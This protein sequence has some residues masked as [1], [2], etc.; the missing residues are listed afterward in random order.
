MNNIVRISVRNLIE[1]IL[2]SGDIDSSKKTV[3]KEAMLLGG[4]IHRKIQKSMGSNYQAEVALKQS[5]ERGVYE[6]IV[7]GRADGIIQEEDMVVVDEIK[8]VYWNLYKVEEPKELHL[9]QAKCYAYMYGSEHGMD[10]MGVQITYCNMETEEVKRFRDV[11]TLKEL[12]MWFVEL[13][14]RYDKWAEFQITWKEK[15][16]DSI[17]NIEFPFVY[18]EGQ[19]E[20]VTSVYKTVLRKKKLFIQAPTGIGKTLATIFPSVKAVGEGLGDKIFYLTAKTITRT[21]AEQ[22]FLELKKQQLQY[23]VLTLTAKD[24]ICFLEECECNPRTC[25]YAKGH[26]DR[27]NEAVYDLLINNDDVSRELLEKHAQQYKVCPFEM[28]LDLSLWVDGIICDYNYLFD[29]NAYL[30]RFFS[31]GVREDYIFLIDEAHNLVERGREMYSADLYKE[32]FLELKKSVKYHDLKLA[33]KLESCNKFLLALKRECETYE[34]IQNIGGFPL[35]LMNLMTEMERV[36]EEIEDGD[37]REKVLELYFRVRM[38]LNIYDRI[39]E[40]YVI[41]TELDGMNQF[42]VRLYCVNPSV[43]LQSCLDRGISTV[44]FSATLLP[45]QYYKNLLSSDPDNYAIYVDSPFGNHQRL[46]LQG[47][48]VS[49]KYTMRSRNMYERYAEYIHDVTKQ[50]KGNYLVFFPSYVFLEQVYTYFTMTDFLEEKGN[51]LVVQSMQM[52][53]QER[54]EFL[55]S[56]EAEQEG[57]LVGFCVMG[58]IFSEGIDLTYDKLIGAIVVGTGLPGVSREREILQNYFQETQNKG[59]DYAYLYPGMNKVM[60][61]AG[62]VIRTAEDKGVILLLDERFSQRQYQEVF[63]REWNDMEVCRLETVESKIKNFWESSS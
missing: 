27:V 41:Y 25:P 60:Q 48:D 1:F 47:N 14:S 3:D 8:G 61:A 58:G 37:I 45:I 13:I 36:L 23:K 21:V 10:Q 59:F 7:E 33:K 43:N 29:P 53:E 15:R 49:T 54:E 56:F 28:M 31:E 50:K 40:N 51:R 63:P 24:K 2:R 22:A 44:Y 19:K 32:E 9:A 11:Y 17:K 34:V 42:K 4:K 46:L 20:L 38:F 5:Y 6:L 39:D 30:R 26:F 35:K 55:E 18:R 16:N 62:R 12:E 52:N 57:I